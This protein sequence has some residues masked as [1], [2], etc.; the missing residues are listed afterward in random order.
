MATTPPQ[1][2]LTVWCLLID[3]AK[4][5]IGNV[6]SVNIPSNSSVDQL[7]KKIKEDSSNTLANVD[8]ACLTVWKCRDEEVKTKKSEDLVDCVGSFD[9]SEESND[10]EEVDPEDSV[11]ELNLASKETLLVEFPGASHVDSCL[12]TCSCRS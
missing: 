5:V 3:H 7:K 10:V 2:D 1:T 8:A 11:G 9:F 12:T 6:F 4:K